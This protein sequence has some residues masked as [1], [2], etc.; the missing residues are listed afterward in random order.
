MTSSLLLSPLLLRAEPVDPDPLQGYYLG[1]GLGLSLL[2]PATGAGLNLSQDSDLGYKLLLG[3]Q[4]DKRWSAEVY[5][6]DMGQA[7]FSYAASGNIAGIIGYRSLGAGALY[8]LPV[9][10]SVQAY[11]GAGI[12]LMKN[13]VQLLSADDADGSA[14]FFGLGAMLRLTPTWS[15]RAGFDYYDTDAQLLSVN[16]IKRFAF[17][18]KRLPVVATPLPAA[19]AV[20]EQAS[21]NNFYIDFKGVVFAEGSIELD[22]T[23][24]RRLDQLAPQLKQLPEGIRFEIRGHAD[25]VGNDLY[26]DKLSTMRARSV[27]DYLSQQGVALSRIDAQ[28]YGDWRSKQVGASTADHALYRRAELIL[29][30]LEKYV[31]D[32]SACPE[33]STLAPS[34]LK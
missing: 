3:Y 7:K 9:N 12:G 4:L 14:V 1:A 23:A 6:A 27:R 5:W 16:L 21:C 18:P 22:S 13:D 10:D 19:P 30:G 34:M 25:D 33:L 8:S 2:Q 17:P 32:A 26:N 11:A 31:D 15:L 29:V 20:V 28:G 24:R